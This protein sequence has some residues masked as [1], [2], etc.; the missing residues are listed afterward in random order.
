ME[1]L[2]VTNALPYAN[3]HLHLG[4]ILGYVQADIW[5]KTKKLLGFTCHYICG[6]DAHGTPIMINAKKHGISPED[7][8]KTFYQSHINDFNEFDINFDYYGSTHTQEN[9]EFAE[10]IFSKLKENNTIITKNI[11]QAYD[12]VENMFLPDR[13]IKGDCPKCNSGD[14]Y[15]DSCEVCGATYSPTE[16]KNPR[17]V[18]SGAAPTKKESIHYFFNLPEFSDMLK[19]WT[20][21]G[22]LQTEIAHKLQEWFEHGLK[23]WDITRDAPYFGFKIPG[24]EHKYFYVWL[25]API[26][27]ISSF[28]KFCDLNPE[29]NFDDYWLN[30]NS[31]TKIVHFIGKDI[32]YFHALFWPAVLTAANF[33]TPDQIYVNGFLTVDG[34]K[35]SKSRGTFIQARTYLKHLDGE[36]LRYYFASKLSRQVEDLDLNLKDFVQ[37]VNSDLVGKL[38]NIASR[39]SGFITKKFNN[40]LSNALEFDC[41]STDQN[42]NN[43]YQEFVGQLNKIS[44]NYQN[45]EYSSAIKDIMVLADNANQFIDYYK[46]WSLM[47]SLD[48]ADH[49]LAHKVCSMGIN[50]YRVLISYLVPV[51]P[52]L[53]SKSSDFLNASTNNWNDLAQPLLGH[54]INEF[55]PLMARID[56]DCIEKIIEESKQ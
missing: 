53:A 54:T 4:H 46:P 8:I 52:K 10:Y 13:F 2:L 23:P 14:Q 12:P 19:N 11:E 43:L 32:T 31:N 48:N 18:V 20:N 55:K 16:L 30:K 24:E 35:M 7:F 29:I 40:T 50:L 33:K 28:K 41:A 17:S 37:K 38:V 5:V 44:S 21:Q 51:L 45:L 36:Y 47:K 42:Y 26:G 34:K 22:H 6:D 56:I 3:G 39:C 15:G 49:D 25:D 9:R 1:K 27:Y